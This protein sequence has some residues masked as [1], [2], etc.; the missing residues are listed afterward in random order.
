MADIDPGEYRRAAGQFMTGVTVVTTVD[1]AGKP[2]GLTVNSFSTV[3]LDPPL[4]LF[5]VDR[6]ADSFDAFM[7]GKGFIIHFLAAEQVE[8]AK[9]F[10][11]KG[12]DRFSEIDW[13]PDPRGRPVLPNPL[14]SFHCDL[15]SYH[16]GGDHV[17][18]VGRVTGIGWG[19][20]DRDALGYFRSSY[21]RSG[22]TNLPEIRTT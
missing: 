20:T 10:A 13:S 9:L 11:T 6:G 18:V 5:S 12:I 17:I 8:L 21:I 3:S 7:S 4:V 16:D 15:E 14:A 22:D 19:D 2:A 1:S